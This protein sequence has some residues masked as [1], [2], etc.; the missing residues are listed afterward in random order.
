MVNIMSNETFGSYFRQKHSLRML[1]IIDKFSRHTYEN[2]IRN[3]PF[4]L[5]ILRDGDIKQYILNRTT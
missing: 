5:V 3:P 2:V 4:L 1:E